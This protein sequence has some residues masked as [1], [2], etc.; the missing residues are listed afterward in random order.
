[1]KN[2]YKLLL[3]LLVSFSSQNVSAQCSSFPCYDGSCGVTVTLQMWDSFGDG[4]NG[5][6]FALFGGCNGAINYQG[7]TPIAYTLWGG[8]YNSVQFTVP[9]GNWAIQIDG[10]SYGYE[11]SWQLNA[12]YSGNFLGGGSGAPYYSAGTAFSVGGG[13][14]VDVLTLSNNY[15]SNAY[16]QWDANDCDYGPTLGCTDPSANNYNS[17]ANQDDGSCQYDIFGCTD[18]GMF[19]YDPLA[20]IDDG[21]CM[22]LYTVYRSDAV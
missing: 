17:S 6:T 22:P 7:S 2:F 20:N 14:P 4:W 1:M 13:C 9:C 16:I 11:I 5:Y 12:T 19:N 18:P 15:N 3:I 21:S 8:S 10:G